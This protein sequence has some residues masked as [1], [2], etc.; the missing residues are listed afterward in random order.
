MKNINM[1]YKKILPGFL[2][3]NRTKFFM[4]QFGDLIQNTLV[5]IFRQKDN[6]LV[7]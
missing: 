2:L 5:S 1:N 3:S 7:L 6:A 4:V